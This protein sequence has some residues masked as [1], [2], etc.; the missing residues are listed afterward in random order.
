MK[1]PRRRSGG[2]HIDLL[3]RA[4]AGQFG[5]EWTSRVVYDPIAHINGLDDLRKRGLLSPEEFEREKA[6]VLGSYRDI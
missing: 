2:G 4:P 5:E 3:G 6:E 1:S